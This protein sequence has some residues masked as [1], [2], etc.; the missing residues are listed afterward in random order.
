VT[1]ILDSYQYF[2]QGYID[3]EKIKKI[4]EKIER[5]KTEVWELRQKYTT[6]KNKQPTNKEKKDLFEK[7]AEIKR[8]IE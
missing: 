1:D 7:L 6:D 4:D 8:M 3:E 5:L 2:V